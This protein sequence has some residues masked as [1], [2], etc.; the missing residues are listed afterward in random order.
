MVGT[1]SHQFAFRKQLFGD[2]LKVGNE[3][4]HDVNVQETRLTDLALIFVHFGFIDVHLRSTKLVQ[5]AVLRRRFESDPCE[6]L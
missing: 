3:Q 5:S 6:D 1:V 4:L 2:A